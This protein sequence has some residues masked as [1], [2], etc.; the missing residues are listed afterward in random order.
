MTKN[1]IRRIVAMILIIMSIAAIALPAAA[2]E[3]ELY[4]TSHGNGRVNI[5]KGPGKDFPVA[6][7]LEEGAKIIWI[8]TYMGGPT[9]WEEIKMSRESQE[10]Y[11]VKSQ[12]ITNVP[13]SSGDLQKKADKRYGSKNLKKGSTGSYVRQLQ[14]DLQA[15]NYSL[16]VDGDFGK[17]TEKAVK[18]FQKKH[19]LSQDGIVG[20]KTRLQLYKVYMGIN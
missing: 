19:G 10:I 14:K 20:P 5:R 18:A 1:T 6:F 16:S 4:I 8:G 2:T 12:Y 13:P 11:Y 15:M 9:G 3:K 17:I 7:Q